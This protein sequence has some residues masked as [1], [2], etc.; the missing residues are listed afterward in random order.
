[1]TGVQT[2]ALRSVSQYYL[3]NTSTS[4]LVSDNS[5]FIISPF[6]HSIVGRNLSCHCMSGPRPI[7]PVDLHT[8][9]S[10]Y[11]ILRSFQQNWSVGNLIHISTFRPSLNSIAAG[12]HYFD[13]HPDGL[14]Q[15]PVISVLFSINP[16]YDFDN[17][18][19]ISPSTNFDGTSI[20]ILGPLPPAYLPEV[21][22]SATYELAAESEISLQYFLFQLQSFL[23]EFYRP[24]TPITPPVTDPLENYQ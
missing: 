13:W 7:I 21:V 11:Y 19:I 22:C 8:Y 14:E 12:D 4:N 10:N 24:V 20:F 1:M 23:D 5:H 2:C 9:K 17:Q 6:P 15:P 18:V 16:A 3:L